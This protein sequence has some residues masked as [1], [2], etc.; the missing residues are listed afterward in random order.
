VRRAD[1]VRVVGEER[2]RLR[3][4]RSAGR[5]VAHVADAEVPLGGRKWREWVSPAN[6]LMRPTPEE[7]YWL[8]WAQA[9][10]AALLPNQAGDAQVGMLRCS[11]LAC[12]ST[13]K[14]HPQLVHVLLL[15]HLRHEAVVLAQ[16]ETRPLA[17][18]DPGSICLKARPYSS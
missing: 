11:A 3:A 12:I 17:G 6:I 8:A 14:A 7:T 13:S 2:L 10:H 9:N 15:E 1:A 18:D 5:G 16:V 4:G